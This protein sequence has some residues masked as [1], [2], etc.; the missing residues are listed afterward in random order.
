MATDLERQIRDHVSR[1]LA[2][3]ISMVDLD[4]WLW[5]A[6]S[7][8]EEIDDPVA[9]DLTYEIIL[10]FAEFDRGHRTEAEVKELLRPIAEPAVTG[11]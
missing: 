2:G 4:R 5:P 3:D 9:R 6:T 10:R 11:A 8:I 7:D 1:Y